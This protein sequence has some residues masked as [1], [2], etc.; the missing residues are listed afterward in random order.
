[1][2]STISLR[3]PV[4]AQRVVD[5]ATR[6]VGEFGNWLLFSAQAIARCFTDVILRLRYR[7]EVARHM[8]DIVVGAGAYVVGGGQVFVIA[9]MAL[10]VGGTLGVQVFSGLQS[11]GAESYTGLVGAY[12]NIRELA[13]IIAAISLAAQVGSSFT[14]EIGAM[15]ISEEIDALETMAVPPL[16][17]LVSTRLI[18]VVLAII[19]LYTFTIFFMLFSTRFVTTQ[20]FGMSPGLYDHYSHAFLPTI[21]VFYSLIK[22]VVFS[23]IIVLVHTYYGY[24]ASG[25]PVGVGRA[26]GKAIRSTIVWIVLVNLLLTVIFWGPNSTVN[27]IG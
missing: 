21:D 26:V 9:A 22:V 7:K 5:V 20:F 8:S 19:P 6:S 17:Y 10:A 14:A 12:I 13:P 24:F 2:A 18:A 4:V 3:P 23:V 27:I 16:V 1:V 11:L 15:R 25:G